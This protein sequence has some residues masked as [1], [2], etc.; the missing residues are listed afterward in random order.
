MYLYHYSK[1]LYPALTTR[2]S[3]A[4]KALSANDIAKAKQDAELYANPGSYFDSISFFFDPIPL[5]MIGDHFNNDHHTWFNGNKL[6]EYVVDTST[7]EPDI[8][9]NIVETPAD[10]KAM[11]S[12]NWDDPKTD[13]DEFF[14]LYMQG[15]NARK[16]RLGEQGKGVA[17]LVKHARQFVGGTERAYLANKQLSK[18]DQESIKGKYAANVPHVM[19][20]PKKGKIKYITTSSVVVGRV[21]TESSKSVNPVSLFSW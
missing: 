16:L 18:E 9:Y 1:E 5:A 3:R 17:N 4:D 20:Y 13:T 10:F 15:K 2:L 8:L 21:D 12:I 14:T 7:F 11:N 6:I 19:L